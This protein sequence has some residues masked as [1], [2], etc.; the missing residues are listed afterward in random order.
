M[1]KGK[2]ILMLSLCTVLY[3]CQPKPIDIE[4]KQGP[5]IL[6]VSSSAIDDHTL[7]VSATYSVN[8]LLGLEDSISGKKKLPKEMLLGD[9]VLTLTPD[10][11]RTDTLQ[12]VSPGFYAKRTLK[13][14][15]GIRYTLHVYDGK[16]GLIGMA[17]TTYFPAP[18]VG[19]LKPKVVRAEDT[20]VQLEVELKDVNRSDYYFLSYYAS[21]N[22]RQ[23]GPI[24]Y[25][26]LE[27]SIASYSPRRL[28]LISGVEM[29]DGKINKTIDIDGKATDDL[30][31][32]IG[33][34][35]KSY[36]D[37]LSAYKKAG[38]YINQL[39]GE[40]I[41][42]PSNIVKGVGFFSLSVP[43]RA[44]FQLKDF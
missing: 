42:L 13:L 8:S 37:Y 27:E 20:T 5:S 29:K 1:K 43:V 10:G 34:I 22:V 4:V 7:V 23:H 28:I 38:A 11:G 3:S 6:T 2:L 9:A 36:Y 32:H 15:T 21:S 35:D 44:V 17:S 39:T 18:G 40:P 26:N 25:D 30:L 12:Y 33:K 16:K 41:N 19:T 24:S 31:V 14:E